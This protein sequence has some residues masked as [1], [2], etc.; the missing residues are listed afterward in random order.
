LQILWEQTQ[1]KLRMGEALERRIPQEEEN[2]RTGSRGESRNPAD[3]WIVEKLR[4]VNPLAQEVRPSPSGFGDSAF[5]EASACSLKSRVAISRVIRDRRSER[6][7]VARDPGESGLG[8]SAFS[9]LK[10][11]WR[12]SEPRVATGPTGI[13]WSANTWH[14]TSAFGVLKGE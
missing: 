8:T 6:G 3:R 10:G 2:Q 5:D 7:Q 14:R 12:K 13:A 4:G 1:E 11:P 9:E